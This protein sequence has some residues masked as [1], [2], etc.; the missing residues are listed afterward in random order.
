VADPGGPVKHKYCLDV[1][2]H[3]DVCPGLRILFV[4]SDFLSLFNP[5]TAFD[6]IQY[7][8]LSFISEVRRGRDRPR[9]ALPAYRHL[10]TG[11]RGCVTLTSVNRFP[12]LVLIYGTRL[13]DIKTAK[14]RGTSRCTS[15]RTLTLPHHLG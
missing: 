6:R 15:D 8:R 13:L 7:S 1:R 2:V 11:S 4:R 12:K 5:R 9:G 14:R 10:R 3:T